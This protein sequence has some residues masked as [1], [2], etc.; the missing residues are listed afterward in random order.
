MRVR[1]AP[2]GLSELEQ[3]IRLSSRL[4]RPDP[5]LA[6][7]PA[8]LKLTAER[9]LEPRLFS[10]ANKAGELSA[11]LGTTE[12]AIVLSLAGGFLGAIAITALFGSL[13]PTPPSDPF[14]F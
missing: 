14:D 5:L 2:L 7:E 13:L 3:L 9:L 12:R 6:L 10:I 8:D 11:A 4:G 1:G